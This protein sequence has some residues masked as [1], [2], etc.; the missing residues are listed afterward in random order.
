M[1]RIKLQKISEKERHTY[2]A[3]YGGVEFKKS[4]GDHYLPTL[5]LKDVKYNGTVVADHLWVNYTKG[6]SRLGQLE[7]N[8]VIVFDGR[9]MTYEKGYYT[10]KRQRE[11]GLGRPTKIHLLNEK[12]KAPLPDALKEKNALVGYIMKVNKE[13]YLA[14]NRPYEKWYVQQYEKWLEEYTK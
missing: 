8:D 3:L 7:D 14:N 9:V 13:F 10:E 6:F 2:E 1:V 5:L 11:Y 4:Y 12:E